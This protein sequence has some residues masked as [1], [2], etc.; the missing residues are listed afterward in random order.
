MCLSVCVS[1]AYERPK[2]EIGREAAFTQVILKVLDTWLSYSSKNTDKN[3]EKHE[4]WLRNPQTNYTHYLLSK[5]SQIW[6]LDSA[7]L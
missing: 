5:L 3:V 6:K 2:G 1:P 7:L 4:S